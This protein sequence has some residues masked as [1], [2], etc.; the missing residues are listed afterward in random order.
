MEIAVSLH[1][2]RVRAHAADAPQTHPQNHKKTTKTNLKYDLLF[3]TLLELSWLPFWTAFA[4]KVAPRLIQNASRSR[5]ATEFCEKCVFDTPPT[6]FQWFPPN[7]PK[8]H[9][10]RVQKKCKF[11]TPK[12]SRKSC[13]IAPTWLANGS[14]S[15]LFW[16][17][18]SLP[19]HLLET[20]CDCFG[21]INQ[22][23]MIQGY[24]HPLEGVS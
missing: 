7:R 2:Q 19:N 15:A 24:R 14:Q 16:E 12:I 1:S 22:F 17:P 20:I 13:N 4:P 6:H 5:V 21:A 3:N 23:L 10:K 9:P 11:R 8:S 18:K